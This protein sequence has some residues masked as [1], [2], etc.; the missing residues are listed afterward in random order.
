MKKGIVLFAILA[1]T[2]AF[3]GQTTLFAQDNILPNPSFEEPYNE[4]LA[5]NWS[6]WHEDSNEKKDCNTERYVVRPVWSPEYNADII[7]DSSR[8]QHIGNQFDTWRGG[9][10]QTFNVTPGQ[11]YRF[12]AWA[13]GRTTNEQYPGASDRSVN[14][15]ARAGIDPAGQGLWTSGNIV[16]SGA[17]NPHDSWQQMVVEATATGDKLTVFLEGDVSGPNNCRGH[18]DVWFDKAEVVSAAPAPTNT[19]T[20]APVVVQVQPTSPPPPTATLVPT[21]TTE[22]TATPVPTETPIPPTAT[23]AGGSICVNAFADSNANGLNDADEGY[24]AG[25]RFTLAQNGA[26]VGEGVSPGTPNPVCFDELVAGSYQVAQTIP[27]TLE[28]TTAGNISIDVAQGKAVGLE[29][30]SRIKQQTDTQETASTDT[31]TTDTAGTDT[32]TTDTAGT[33]TTGT[34]TNTTDT[35][36]TA[37]TD[38]TEGEGGLGTLEIVALAII[39]L[40]VVLLGAVVFLLLRQRS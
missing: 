8:S 20:P 37:G 16:W 3:F 13:W 29:F 10:F 35:T 23:P 32:A 11:T 6:P 27:N 22:P 34:D 18:L 1:V 9:V 39:G 38:S 28:M 36:D 40:A 25:I 26:I 30:G 33:D 4:G 19:P 2:A 14:L 21:A 15:R 12:S 7:L 31:G 24:M 17:V 5:Q